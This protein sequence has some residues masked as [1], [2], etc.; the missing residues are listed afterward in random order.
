[1]R[2]IIRLAGLIGLL[3]LAGCQVGPKEYFVVNFKENSAL[4]YQ[5]VSERDIELNLEGGGTAKKSRRQKTQKMSEKLKLVIVYKPIKVDP[6]GLTTIEATCES[7]EVTRKSFT[8]K[9]TT[10][11]AVRSLRGKKYTFEVTPSGKFEDYANLQKVVEELGKKAFTQKISKHGRVK[12]PD[13]ISDFVALQW[14]FWDSAATIDKP[15][16]GAK[17]GQS[18]KALQFIPVPMPRAVVKETTYELTEIKETPAGRVAVITGSYTLSDQRVKNWPKPYL[19]KFRMK[20]MFGFLRNYKT[21]SINGTGRQIFNLDTGQ[22]ESEQ[23]QYQV[24]VEADFLMPL[25]DT[26]PKLIIQQK[27]EVQL[28]DQ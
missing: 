10:S 13:M 3:A 11:D 5:L 17:V 26:R 20:G 9:K 18:W 2:T 16:E 12:D 23:Q 8:G 25:G 4:R 24:D 14:Y 7:A 15:V 27:I 19:G 1:L 28:L 22:V 21:T 6:Y